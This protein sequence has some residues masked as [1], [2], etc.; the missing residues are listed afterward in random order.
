MVLALL[1]SVKATTFEVDCTETGAEL[2]TPAALAVGDDFAVKLAGGAEFLLKIVAAPPAGIAGQSYIA[3]DTKSQAS[4]VVKPT[5]GGLRVTIDDFEHNKIYS[6]RVRNGV[7]EAS[8][9][10]TSGGE[11]DVCGTCGGDLAAPSATTRTSRLKAATLGA[12]NAFPLAEQRA[13]VDVL[14]AF[15]QG[16]VSRSAA[17]GYDTITNF[18]E[19]AVSKMN[20]V[21]EKSRLADKLSYRLVGVIEVDATYDV[22]N[23]NLLNAL[24]LRNAGAL[25]PVG[26]AREKCGADTI[27][28]L[29][30][31]DRDKSAT[32]GLG[33]EYL[34]NSWS[35]ATF[36]ATGYTC[37]ICDIKT[38]Y[39]RYT[40]SHEQGHNMGCGH[41][42]ARVASGAEIDLGPQLYSYSAAYYLWIG[43]E[44]PVLGLAAIR[45]PAATISWMP[46]ARIATRSWP[47]I[48]PLLPAERTIQCRTSLHPR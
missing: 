43:G 2:E 6:V 33:Y 3:R 37:N 25:A 42:D 30:D 22:I 29:I 15:D 16:A 28:L 8:M 13:V 41:A 18:A 17:L 10:D 34:S 4:A 5:K 36:D 47:T 19:Y 20:T 1:L 32:S 48:I 44:G 26:V 31:R 39:D 9:H 27:T 38:V 46:P 21:L 24:R 14:V 12:A 23:D 40:M 11:S 35:Y 45:I 7:A